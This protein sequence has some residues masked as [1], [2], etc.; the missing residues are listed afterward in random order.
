MQ[1]EGAD[2][3]FLA[4]PDLL[5]VV[6]WLTPAGTEDEGGIAQPAYIN[7]DVTLLEAP[8]GNRMEVRKHCTPLH[9]RG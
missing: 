1:A 6:V 2:G 3:Y 4:A 7:F 9:A 5:Q 8:I